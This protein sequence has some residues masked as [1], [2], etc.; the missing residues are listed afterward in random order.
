MTGSR[1][2]RTVRQAFDT[3]CPIDECHPF[4]MYLNF[5]VVVQS[6]HSSHEQQ[7]G[8][9]QVAFINPPVLKLDFT[10]GRQRG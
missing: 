8:A 10:G 7:I 6:L 4:G 3:T 1:K 9:A 2:C 5:N